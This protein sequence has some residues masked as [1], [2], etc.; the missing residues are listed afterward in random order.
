MKSF[1]VMLGLVMAIALVAGC[2]SE[3]SGNGNGGTGNGNGETEPLTGT[4]EYTGTWMGTWL[5]DDITGTFEFTVNFTA[6]T[7]SGTMNSGYRGTIDGTIAD[8]IM[9]ASGTVTT[10]AVTWTGTV[11]P[12]GSGIAGDWE[13]TVSYVDGSGTWSGSDTSTG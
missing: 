5:G 11:D 7:V 3:D 9:N 2:T 1:I 8:R 10:Y 6:G 13:C 12:D 4:A